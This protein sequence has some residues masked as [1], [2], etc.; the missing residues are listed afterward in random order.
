MYTGMDILPVGLST[1]R[2]KTDE[3]LLWVRTIGGD[4]VIFEQNF[5]Y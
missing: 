2:M 1:G 4:N 3:E 5:Y